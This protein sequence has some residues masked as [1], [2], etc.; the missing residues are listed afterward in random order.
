M[1][2]WPQESFLVGS[3]L[4]NTLH[5]KVIQILAEEFNCTI[6]TLQPTTGPGNI[7]GW[8]SLSHIIAISRIEEE[9]CLSYD[10]TAIARIQKIED[11]FTCNE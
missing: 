10:V 5:D 2:I 6:Q 11:F 7:A 3:M 1:I 4:D 9:T 8:T